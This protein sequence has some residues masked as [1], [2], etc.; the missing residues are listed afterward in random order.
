[1]MLHSDPMQLF[2]AAERAVSN[3]TSSMA[4]EL[5][6]ESYHAADVG[7]LKPTLLNILKTEIGFS[8]VGGFFHANFLA[9]I[10]PDPTHVATAARIALEIR[11][12][13][14]E[15]LMAFA[16]YEWGSGLIKTQNRSNFLQRLSAA[17]I[18]ELMSLA[19]STVEAAFARAFTCRVINSI[20]RI[21]LV[22]PMIGHTGH[23]PT[24]LT[25]SIARELHATG[26]KFKL[27]SPQDLLMPP[28]SNYL[29]TN[30]SISIDEAKIENLATL[31]PDGVELTLSLPRYSLPLRWRRLATDI[32]AYDPDLILY[33]GFF[34]PWM[35]PLFVHRPVVAMSVHSLPPIVPADVILSA[36]ETVAGCHLR[37]WGPVL[38]PALVH[39][40]PFRVAAKPLISGVSRTELRVAHDATLLITVGGRLKK[41]MTTEWS[42]RLSELM[43]RRPE[44]SLLLVGSNDVKSTAFGDILSHRIQILGPRSDVGDLLACSDIYINPPRMGGGFSVAEAMAAGLPVVSLA[45]GDGGD[46]LGPFAARDIEGYWHQLEYYLDNP[47]IRHRDG[48][49]LKARFDERLDLSRSG[50]S[51]I[52]AGNVAISLFNA[53]RIVSDFSSP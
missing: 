18:P 8:G 33:I 2:D 19:A 15:R 37:P 5:L 34:A 42:Q 10:D 17:R 3:P 35:E 4:W 27:F 50:P 24:A 14:A 51:L 28:L 16:T 41:E 47:S 6:L 7:N 25:L 31:L 13:D 9:M 23:T 52:T 29:G 44:I 36:D 48:H 11:P 53:R 26:T 1:V 45:D 40:H 21:A 12:V 39:F 32:A 22:T 49:Q 20:R 46:K 30:Q 38:P 43:I